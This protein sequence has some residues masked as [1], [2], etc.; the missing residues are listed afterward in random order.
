MEPLPIHLADFLSNIGKEAFK[1]V[2]KY[3]SLAEVLP[4]KFAEKRLKTAPFSAL[5]RKNG[6]GIRISK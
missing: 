2:N 6:R 1:K 4:P 3:N 5:L